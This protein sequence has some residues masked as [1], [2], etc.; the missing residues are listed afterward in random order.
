MKRN[1]YSFDGCLVVFIYLISI[2]I[3]VVIGKVMWKAIHVES[4]IQAVIW[5]LLWNAFSAIVIS[6]FVYWM[7]LFI[8]DR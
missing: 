6:L 4:A 1:K 8:K 7:S 5:F 2:A 3:W